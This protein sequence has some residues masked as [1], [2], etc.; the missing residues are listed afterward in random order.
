MPTFQLV[1]DEPVP[2]DRFRFRIR[3]WRQAGLPS[4]VLSSPLPGR[5]PPNYCGAVLA[6]FVFRNF[7]G[8]SV[9]VPVFFAV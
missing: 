5:P 6:N 2:V 3:I 7:P 8:Y 4:L 1:V 9:P